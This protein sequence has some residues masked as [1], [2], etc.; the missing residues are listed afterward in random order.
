M[1]PLM[2]HWHLH[3]TVGR[4]L[5]KTS[6]PLTEIFAVGRHCT[7]KLGGGG[8]GAVS[9][10]E[11]PAKS[12]TLSST[13]YA[14]L[15]LREFQ[16]KMSIT[17]GLRWRCWSVEPVLVHNRPGHRK[18]ST[19]IP[20]SMSACIRRE[21]PRQRW[22]QRIDSPPVHWYPRSTKCEWCCLVSTGR[23]CT[24]DQVAKYLLET[25]RTLAFIGT[26]STPFVTSWSRFTVGK[27]SKHTPQELPHRTPIN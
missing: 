22:Y 17:D 13:T 20:S 16:N 11:F 26:R 2:D 6:N 9:F 5:K 25:W 1:L 4:C 8:G 27:V 12:T 21:N 15:R 23:R 10:A 24:A 19:S 3:P 14:E 7:E 18:T